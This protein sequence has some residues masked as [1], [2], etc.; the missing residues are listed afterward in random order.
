MDI[1]KQNEVFLELLI[2]LKKL[3]E[4][5]KNA[6]ENYA[7]SIMDAHSNTPLS[8]KLSLILEKENKEIVRMNYDIQTINNLELEIEAINSRTDITDEIKSN[9]KNDKYKSFFTK[10]ENV[11]ETNS[12]TVVS[13]MEV[14]NLGISE[15]DKIIK[16]T[17]E[18]QKFQAKIDKVSAK[19]SDLAAKRQ[20]NQRSPNWTM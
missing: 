7:K 20:K 6:S 3:V 13:N 2:Y 11:Y 16:H 12:G 15:F 4:K 10:Y 1:S 8:D 19:I 18:Y 17:K 5:E 9:L 14:Y